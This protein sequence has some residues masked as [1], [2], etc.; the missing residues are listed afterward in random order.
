[1]AKI[2]ID[3]LGE[4]GERVRRQ[5]RA[6]SSPTAASSEP[7][8]AGGAPKKSSA[9]AGASRSSFYDKVCENP[10]DATN[11]TS[12][13]EFAKTHDIDFHRGPSAAAAGMDTAKGANFIYSNGGQMADYW[14][15]KQGSQTDV[16]VDRRFRRPPAPAA[17][18]RRSH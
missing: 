2:S 11:V 14:G 15:V 17:N 4:T 8:H 6:W 18:A 16:A 12:C 1:L 3:S 5:A 10:N 13:V 9:K 7:A